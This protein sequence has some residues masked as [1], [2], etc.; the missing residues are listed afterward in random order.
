MYCKK[1]GTIQVG[2][3]VFCPICGTELPKLTYPVHYD[4]D[5][6]DFFVAD[7][8]ITIPPL[9]A[10]MFELTFDIGQDFLTMY[11]DLDEYLSHWG[12]YFDSVFE[13]A[14]PYFTKLL[15]NMVNYFYNW[16]LENDIDCISQSD[17][18]DIVLDMLDID[19]DMKIFN[20]WADA[21]IEQIDKIS[22][23]RTAQRSSRSR[24][25]GGGFGIKGAVKGAIK[26]GMLNFGTDILRGIGD[27]YVD[28]KDAELIKKL[29]RETGQ[30]VR[31]IF[32]LQRL[33]FKYYLHVMRFSF[34]LYIEDYCEADYIKACDYMISSLISVEDMRSDML[35]ETGAVQAYTKLLRELILRYPFD[36]RP[37][38]NLI[39]TAG[40][41]ANQIE[42][43][44]EDADITPFFD[45]QVLFSVQ[46]YIIELQS[47]F[48]NLSAH[49][50][51]DYVQ[52]LGRLV[53]GCKCMH[54]VKDVRKLYYQF[55]DKLKNM[56]LIK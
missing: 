56:G 51:V 7:E 50:K 12:T 17:F 42:V 1:C 3:A 29:K 5:S 2:D 46:E 38:V 15:G 54:D 13:N 22:A 39:E 55:Y 6:V 27:S 18:I 34:G 33:F 44:V 16:L 37:Y 47:N 4:D 35:F 36:P 25:Q 14:I 49:Q 53:L 23:I 24:W 32:R 26:A 20:D 10:K 43:L 41:E 30:I 40:C 19:E 52:R 48:S 31:P 45:V 21:V 28:K 8:H 11:G 9:I